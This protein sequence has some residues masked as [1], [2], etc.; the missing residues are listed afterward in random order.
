MNFEFH[1]GMLWS[2]IANE[3]GAREFTE[4]SNYGDEWFNMAEYLM[5]NVFENDVSEFARQSE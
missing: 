3:I 1:H 5:D 2:K 4:V